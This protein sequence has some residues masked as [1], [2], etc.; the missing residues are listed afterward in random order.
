MSMM[1]M[2]RLALAGLIIF[3]ATAARAADWHHLHLTATDTTKAAEWYAKYMGGEV[4]KFGAMDLA[5]FEGMTVIFFKKEAGFE[6]SVGSSVDH[7]GWS[8]KDLDAK[9]EEFKAAEIKI[10]SEPVSF[11]KIKFAFI[12]DPWGTKIEVMQDPDL[13]GFHH[14][15][16]HATDPAAVTQWYADALGGEVT[17]FGGALPAVKYDGMW[18]IV[19]RSREA[20]APTIGRAV[21][22]LGFSFPDLDKAAEELKAKGVKFTLEPRPFGSLRIAF[23]EDPIGVRIELV[24]PAAQ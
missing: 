4:Q 23:I 11:G 17:R 14:V 9:M 18:L 6:G 24:Q 20:K 10:I 19:Q 22:H 21:D 3:G 12:E 2:G 5:A 15:H 16:L 1:R 13:Y 7:V 8:F